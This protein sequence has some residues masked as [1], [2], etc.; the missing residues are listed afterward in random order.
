MITATLDRYIEESIASFDTIPADR[1]PLLDEL[2]GY[3]EDRLTSDKDVKLIFICT[4]NS[5]RS[6][7][8]QIWAQTAAYFFKVPNIHT[9]SGGTEATAFNP[10]AV[11]A[12]KRAGFQIEKQ[13]DSNNPAY[14]VTFNETARPIRAFSKVYTDDPN[15]QSDYGAVMTCN[16]ADQNCPIVHGAEKRISLTYEDPKD[17]DGTEHEQQAYDERSRQIGT[18]MLYVFSNISKSDD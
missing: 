16:S 2:S 1:K 11:E 9:Y 7:L 13:P 8:S 12:L 18:E 5:R 14:L 17:Y 3:I 15:P 6:H 10:R 4:H